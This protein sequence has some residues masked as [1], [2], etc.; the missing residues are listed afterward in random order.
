MSQPTTDEAVVS[1][2]RRTPSVSPFTPIGWCSGAVIFAVMLVLRVIYAN[3]FRFDTDEPQHLHVVWGWANGY[4]QYRDIFDN[5]GPDSF[6]LLCVPLFRVL[7]ERADILIP[8]R[9]AMI[10]LFAISLWCIYQIG[11]ALFSR[12]VGLWA[13]ILCGFYPEFFLTSFRV[14]CTDNLWTVLWLLALVAAVRMP[15]TAKRA[16]IVGLL[17]G[18]AFAVTVK[19]GLMVGSLGL[20]TAAVITLAPDGSVEEARLEIHRHAGMRVRVLGLIVVPVPRD[21]AFLAARGALQANSS[22]A[23]SATISCHGPKTGSRS[24]RISCGSLF[25]R[26]WCWALFDSSNSR[27]VTRL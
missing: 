19:T 10:P 2:D 18:A 13:A 1:P 3:H 27:R 8:M 7:G 22:I 23:I 9:L 21:A 24:T 16:V 11:T 20:T 15:F 6:H 4:L 14:S 12:Q 26:R 25:L 5:H 17:L